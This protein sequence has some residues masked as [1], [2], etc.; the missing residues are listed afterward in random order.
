VSIV[1]AQGLPEKW[2]FK[3]QFHVF[4]VPSMGDQPFEERYKFVQDYFKKNKVQWVK[5]VE[6]TVCKSKEHLMEELQKVTDDKGEGLMLRE[7]GS[8]YIGKRS[9]TLLKVKKF[10]DDDAEVIG[11]EKGKGRNAG[12]CG[13][14]KCKMIGSGKEFKV[15]TGL[16]DKVRKNV[17]ILSKCLHRLSTIANSYMIFSHQRLELPSYIGMYAG[18]CDSVRWSANIPIRYFELTRDGVPRFPSYVVSKFWF[19][20]C[21]ELTYCQGERAD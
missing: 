18:G 15:G 1:K 3:I 6:H 7:P 14:L 20:E 5:V 2:K 13:A 4:D 11:H 8:L 21:F 12:V 10:L 16:S 9:K 17:S 19:R